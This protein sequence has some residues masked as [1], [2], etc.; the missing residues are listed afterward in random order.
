MYVLCF[1]LPIPYSFAGNIE[2][3]F[4]ITNVTADSNSEAQLNIIKNNSKSIDIIAPQIYS[5][6]EDGLISGN[7]DPKLQTLANEF[8][9]KIMPLIVNQNFNQEQFHKFLRNPIAQEKA[10]SAMV[11]LCKKYLFYGIQFDFENIHVNDKNEYTR[12]FQLAADKLHQNGFSISVA[13]VSQT[14][15]EFHN[16]YER[17][18][19]ENWSGAYDYQALALNA[20]FISIMS[21]DLHTSLTTPGPI[22]P[23][24]WVEKTIQSILKVAP[25]AKISLGI[26]AYSGYWT[27][28]QS[29]VG[30][31]PYQYTFRSKEIAMSYTKVTKLL[32]DLNQS[33]NW[34]PQWKS[35]YAMFTNNDRNE[36][37]FIEDSKSFMAKLELIKQY[38]LRGISVWKLG[39][40]DPKIWDEI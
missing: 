24:D 26:P 15:N 20:D 29:G 14:G 30:T 32:H 2:K 18:F 3:L 31:I 13:V 27:L 6:D 4:Y 33:L 12:F 40:E 1:I 35:Y 39:L 34:Q 9:I 19:F 8:N 36:F 5:I 25:A 16:E 38:H 28:G 10:I 7:L 17:W 21:Y 22:A 23:Y 37:I 11:D